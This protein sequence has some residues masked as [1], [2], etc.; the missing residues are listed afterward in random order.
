MQ[1]AFKTPIVVPP[2]PQ[3][4]PVPPD[5]VAGVSNLQVNHAPDMTKEQMVQAMAQMSGMNMEWSQK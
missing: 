3:P 5:V 4:L 2:T 1:L